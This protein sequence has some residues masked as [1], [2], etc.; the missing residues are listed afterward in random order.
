MLIQICEWLK[1]QLP[2]AEVSKVEVSS[3]LT[4]S[5]AAI[6]QGAYGMSPTMQR[7]MKAQV[8]TIT[9]LIGS[10][11]PCLH[12]NPTTVLATM[13]QSIVYVC[14]KESSFDFTS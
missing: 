1:A 7:Y 12:H 8:N 13:M 11:G 5:P 10:P 4:D 14:G 2:E 6:T 9:S 3:R